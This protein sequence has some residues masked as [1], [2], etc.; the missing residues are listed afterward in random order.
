MVCTSCFTVM[1]LFKY[2]IMLKLVLNTYSLVI[3]VN[4]RGIYVRFLWKAYECHTG[5]KNLIYIQDYLIFGAQ[6]TTLLYCCA[7]YVCFNITFH[8][9]V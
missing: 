6:F 1:M 4:L 9:M 8:I 2:R 3:D 5:S 7:W